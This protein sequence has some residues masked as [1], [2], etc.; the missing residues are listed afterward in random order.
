MAP[1]IPVVIIAPMETFATTEPNLEEEKETGGAGFSA[2]NLDFS[3]GSIVIDYVLCVCFVSFDAG[4]RNDC[5][6]HTFRC[7]FKIRQ[8]KVGSETV[9]VLHH[10]KNAIKFVL[11]QF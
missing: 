6:T 5:A 4:R 1:R 9:R 3:V 10:A 8:R 2:N 7:K 11:Q